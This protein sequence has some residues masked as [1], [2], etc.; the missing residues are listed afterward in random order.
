MATTKTNTRPF[1]I[2]CRLSK[3]TDGTLETVQQQEDLCR[4]YAGDRLPLDDNHVYVDASL[5]AWKRRNGR[6]IKRPAWDAMMAAAERG[7]L[8]GVL[9]YAVDRFTRRPADLEALIDLAELRGL[10]IDGPRSGRLDLS[11]ATGRQQA[12]WMALQAASE[13]DNTSERIK[14]TLGRKMREGKPMCAGRAFGFETGGLVQRPTEVKV[15]RELARRALA[16]EPLQHLAEHLNARGIRTVNGNGWTGANVGRIL[17]QHR[18]G[19]K[20]EHHGELV[21][22][23]HSADEPVLDAETYDAIQALLT[24]RRR[25][26]RPSGRFLLTGVLVCK[27]CGIAMNGA[28][29]TKRAADGSAVRQYRCPPPRK[30][31]TGERLGGGCL[32]SIK[33]GPVEDAVAEF[34]TTLLASPTIATKVRKREQAMSAAR[35][36]RRDAVEAAEDALAD[37]EVKLASGEI[38]R[39]AYDRAKPIHDRN[40]ARAQ[41]ALVEVTAA[42]TV[43]LPP[44]IAALDWAEAT[45]DEKRALIRRYHVTITIA[46]A[47]SRKWEPERIVI[48][49]G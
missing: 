29:K 26:A 36:V 14:A 10:I 20:V 34:M 8:A 35:K 19:G 12:R 44:A 45:D 17:G 4:S 38:I 43:P 46:R 49:A 5:S 41:A 11:T 1:A 21:A 13:S 25:G 15:V 31:A 3:A 28:T 27:D 6:P 18:H 39:R 40:L 30:S 7:E 37:L 47:T 9:V 22:N 2:Y 33:A 23:I 16:G 42:G 32:S 48:D 24:S